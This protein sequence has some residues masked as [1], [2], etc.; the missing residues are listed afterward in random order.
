MI[1]KRKKG[2][3]VAV[4]LTA[5]LAW[6]IGMGLAGDVLESVLINSVP[7]FRAAEAG[8]TGF[9]ED[10]FDG[11]GR[12]GRIEKN[13]IVIDDSLRRL[14]GSVKYHSQTNGAISRSQFRVGKIV[15]YRINAQ[16]EITGLWL[17]GD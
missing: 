12:I 13:E 5:L 10:D 4:L 11:T 17:L 2:R 3:K 6:T 8:E 7:G 1:V 9:I 14:S 15:G 16:G